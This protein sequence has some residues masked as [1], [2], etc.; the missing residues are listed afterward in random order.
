MPGRGGGGPGSRRR[1]PRPL[2]S[3]AHPS[4]APEGGWGRGMASAG[5]GGG[6]EADTKPF[7]RLPSSSSCSSREGKVSPAPVRG[8]TGRPRLRDLRGGPARGK[9]RWQW[10]PHPLCPHPA[11]RETS[12][13][14]P[15]LCGVAGRG[16]CSV[17]A[18]PLRRRAGD[19]G[20]GRGRGAREWGLREGGRVTF[21][22]GSCGTFSGLP[23]EWVRG[24]RGCGRGGSRCG[25]ARVA[26]EVGTL[27]EFTCGDA[28]RVSS[29]PRARRVA[30][31]VPS[32]DP[33]RVFGRCAGQTLPGTKLPPPGAKAPRG[34]R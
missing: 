30:R 5:A 19:R 17:H 15:G 12:G 32:A 29:A 6:R 4:Q 10:R 20:D 34:S 11:R 2:G 28:C 13:R 26:A 24:R 8:A 33:A 9:G 1:L 31:P 23:R 18:P 27:I 25:C 22:A 3:P 16:C 7:P 14:G 21:R